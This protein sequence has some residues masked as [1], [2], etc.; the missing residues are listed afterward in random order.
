[1]KIIEEKHNN[2][3]PEPN[4]QKYRMRCPRCGSLLEFTESEI[5]VIQIYGD[6]VLNPDHFEEYIICPICSHESNIWPKF[7]KRKGVYN[8][9]HYFELRS[10]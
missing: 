5:D 4:E 3:N 8:F 6:G 7:F 2:I 1:M 9:F 10:K